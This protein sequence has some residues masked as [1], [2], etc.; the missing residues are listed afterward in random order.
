VLVGEAV[1]VGVGGLVGVLV[2]VEAS[3]L[4]WRFSLNPMA[5]MATPAMMMPMV[6]PAIILIAGWFLTGNIHFLTEPEV[7]DA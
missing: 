3:A 7:L 1:W 5:A 2:A 4:N 6:R